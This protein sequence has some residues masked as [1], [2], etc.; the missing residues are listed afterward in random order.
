MD[1]IVE[2][3]TRLGH[4]MALIRRQKRLS[5][6]KFADLIGLTRQQVSNYERGA[7]Q[8]PSHFVVRRLAEIAGIPIEQLTDR[9][10]REEDIKS[11]VEIK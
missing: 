4:N 9:T 11:D 8:E 3:G 6:E 2:F 10:L 7:A 1:D 5:Q